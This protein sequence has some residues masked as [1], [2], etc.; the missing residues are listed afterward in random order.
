MQYDQL[1]S[2]LE[3]LLKENSRCII[4]IDGRCAGGKTTLSNLLAGRFP[5][6]V[7]HMDDFYLPVEQRV[8]GWE[9]IPC[10]NMDFGRMIKTVLQPAKKGKAAAVSGRDYRSAAYHSGRQLFALS[11]AFTVL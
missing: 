1:I 7:F 2:D 3:E 5:A 4:G 8:A 9:K 6:R 11:G 10:A